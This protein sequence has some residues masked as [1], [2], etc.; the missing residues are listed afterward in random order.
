MRDAHEGPLGPCFV[1]GGEGSGE[2]AEEGNNAKVGSPRHSTVQPL[3]VGVLGRVDIVDGGV[4]LRHGLKSIA[5]R[6]NK[7]ASK[8]DE[9]RQHIG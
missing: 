4:A 8:R 6:Q 5:Q 9:V 3:L 7:L 1:D 2:D